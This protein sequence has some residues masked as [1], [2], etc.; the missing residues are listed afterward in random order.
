MAIKPVAVVDYELVIRTLQEALA[1]DKDPAK[2]AAAKGWRVFKTAETDAKGNQL[3]I[4][5]MLPAIPD[6]V[7]AC[8]VAI[9]LSRAA[10]YSSVSEPAHS[11]ATWLAP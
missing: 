6:S 9:W 8:A 7:V 1:R 5:V 3:Y 4:H 10:T 11:T 2:V